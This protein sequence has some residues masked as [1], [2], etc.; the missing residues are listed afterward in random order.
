VS[1]LALYFASIFGLVMKVIE[2]PDYFDDI[3]A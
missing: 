3:G 1:F 2:K